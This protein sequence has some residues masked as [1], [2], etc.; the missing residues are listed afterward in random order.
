MTRAAIASEL[1]DP[2]CYPHPPARVETLETHISHLFFAGERVYKVKKPV[3]LGF[4]DFTTLE[5]RR[6]F[7]DEEVRL[8]QPLAARIYLGVLPVTRDA[9]GRIRVG[10]AREPSEPAGEPIEYAI[11]M[12]RL[13]AE[14]M[15]DRLLDEGVI[16]NAELGALASR[17]AQFH[18]AQPTG[19]GVDEHGAADAVASL[20]RGNFAAIGAAACLPDPAHA[21]SAA[22][23]S[24]V[25]RTWTGLRATL[26][27]RVAGGRVRE[28]HGDL[29]AGNICLLPEEIVVYDR[30]EFSA[31]YRCCDVACDLAFLA[32]DMDRRGYRAFSSYLARRYAEIAHDPE[33][34]ELLRFYK[35]YRALVRCKVAA[36][37]AEDRAFDDA[38]RAGARREA[39]D[40]LNLAATYE[41][42]PVMVLVCGLPATGKSWLATELARPLGAAHLASDLRR[43]IL[44]HLPREAHAGE[45][46]D[47]GLYAPEMKARTYR[48]LLAA[49]LRTL[50]SGRSVIVDAS[51][52]ARA[53]RARFVAGARRSR[54]PV[55]LVHVTAGESLVRARLAARAHD[56]HSLSDADLSVHR[57][58]ALAFELPDELSDAERLDVESERESPE[59]TLTRVLTKAQAQLDEA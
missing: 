37:R 25:E 20:V 48:S 3:D 24:R 43:K 35:S 4:L 50:R 54:V 21:L 7:C 1:L 15:L 49:A 38:A 28:G 13:P 12:V 46:F 8:N 58:A 29:H 32:M 14:R 26:A 56:P 44:A 11:E 27:A 45:A 9:H 47:S 36:I 19:A 57:R 39:L 41:L 34:S 30:L 22:I 40:Y 16:D 51:F 42:P 18:A 23:A 2:A 5:R 6:F 55:V 17:L 59:Q 31:A 52:A 53:W 33:L 10:G